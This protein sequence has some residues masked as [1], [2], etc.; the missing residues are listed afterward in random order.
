MKSRRIEKRLDTTEQTI[1]VRQL[2][3][4]PN[5]TVNASNPAFAKVVEEEVRGELAT[6]KTLIQESAELP[7]RQ[8][9]EL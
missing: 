6:L 9:F 3:T 7:A 2:I 4:K 8:T 5:F 1:M